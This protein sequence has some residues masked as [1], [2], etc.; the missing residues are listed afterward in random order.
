MLEAMA[1]IAPSQPNEAMA[2]T[3]SRRNGTISL[4]PNCRVK[5]P[6]KFLSKVQIDSKSGLGS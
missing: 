2:R 3:A 1:R 5:I 4:D 6:E